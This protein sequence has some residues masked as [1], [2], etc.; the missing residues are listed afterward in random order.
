MMAKYQYMLKGDAETSNKDAEK[1]AAYTMNTYMDGYN[2]EAATVY[3]IFDD[4]RYVKTKLPKKGAVITS[5][6]AEK[7]KLKNGDAFLLKEQYEDKLIRFQVRGILD[8][9]TTIGVYLS[10]SYTRIFAMWIRIIIVHTFRTPGSRISA[11][12]RFSARSPRVMS[13]RWQISSRYPW[14]ICSRSWRAL[15]L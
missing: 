13:R 3:G 1:F 6:M 2:Q 14:G 4:S 9:P 10:H 5:G 12:I 7:Y 8:S 11:P 15:L